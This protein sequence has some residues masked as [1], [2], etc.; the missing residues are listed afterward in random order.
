MESLAEFSS[1]LTYELDLCK[2]FSLYFFFCYCI[3][4]ACPI[5]RYAPCFCCWLDAVS[6]L[7]FNFV[8]LA[9]FPLSKLEHMRHKM[10]ASESRGVAC[11]LRC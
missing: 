6:K 9:K 7:A 3:F 10:K 4:K 5:L 8:Q 2:L 1:K 11:F